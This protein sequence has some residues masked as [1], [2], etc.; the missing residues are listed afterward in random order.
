MGQNYAKFRWVS[1]RRILT[2]WRSSHG[3]LAAPFKRSNQTVNWASLTR[4]SVGDWHSLHQWSQNS[5][6]WFAWCSVWF[7]FPQLPCVMVPTLH[8]TEDE[9]HTTAHKNTMA[10]IY[11]IAIRSLSFP[12]MKRECRRFMAES[13]FTWERSKR[14][15]QSWQMEEFN[16]F[17]A[18]WY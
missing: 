4:A 15:S 17:K 18:L 11:K 8:F 1:Q 9:W 7:T 12:L 16:F 3:N 10:A 13:V 5:G 14:V 2:C 6:M